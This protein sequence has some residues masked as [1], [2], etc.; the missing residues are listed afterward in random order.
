MKK[1]TPRGY[2]LNVI[3]LYFFELYYAIVFALSDF[4]LFWVRFI[5]GIIV[6]LAFMIPN[7]IYFRKR[8]DLFYRNTVVNADKQPDISENKDKLQDEISIG[9]E[10]AS[11]K[12]YVSASDEIID[13]I[14]KLNALKERGV[15]T[16]Q[17]FQEKKNQ[18]LKRI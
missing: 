14:K 6:G 8:K 11:K 4:Y 17:E 10:M 12:S 2:I 7:L 18:L 1:M 3:Y 15:L 9:D 16:E 13:T 5:A